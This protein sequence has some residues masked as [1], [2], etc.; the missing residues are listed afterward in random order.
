MPASLI[1]AGIVT[2]LC[3][4]PARQRPAPEETGDSSFS[5]FLI[6]AAEG[7]KLQWRVRFFCLRRYLGLL[8]NNKIFLI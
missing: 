5:L 7:E 1:Y 4:G 6:E 3:Q 8:Y 2:V